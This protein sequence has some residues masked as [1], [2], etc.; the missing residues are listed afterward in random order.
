MS[1]TRIKVV[2]DPETIKSQLRKDEKFSKGV[3]LYAVYQIALGK[4][5]EEVQALYC[6]S[7]KSICNWV[8]RYNT[9]GIEGLK[10]KPRS[11]RRSRLSSEQKEILKAVI[12]QSPM[13][14]GFSSGVWT[15]ALVAEYIKNK[16]SVSYKKANIY[17]ILHSLGLSYQK[18][19]GFFPEKANREI[20]IEAIKK[21]SDARRQQCSYI[22]R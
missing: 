5:A 14:E 10:D 9:E 16:F 12:L 20:Q 19:R 18:G 6:S 2:A 3:R 8:H 21:T 13:E 17:N 15:W 1:K 22:C 7:H 11:G 4:K